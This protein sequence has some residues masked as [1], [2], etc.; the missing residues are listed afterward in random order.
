MQSGYF[1]LEGLM[2]RDERSFVG[3]IGA[4]RQW[5]YVQCNGAVARWGYC[6]RLG[7]LR[8]FGVKSKLRFRFMGLSDFLCRI[9]SR[10]EP[11][12]AA[13]TGAYN[14]VS[15]SPAFASVYVKAGGVL[16]LFY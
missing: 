10:H 14:A 9:Q 6:A 3:P 1:A 8:F 5:D 16:R 13:A 11:G 7:S 15:I 2:C 12:P 4:A